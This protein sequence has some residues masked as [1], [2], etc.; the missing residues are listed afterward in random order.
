LVANDKEWYARIKEGDE[1]AFEALFRAHYAVLCGFARKFVADSETA[2]E[3]VQELFTQMWDRRAT[4]NPETSLKAYLFTAIRNSCLNHLKH[5]AV[6]SRHQE[7]ARSMEVAHAADPSEALQTAELEARIHLEIDALPERCREIF[8]LSRFQGL[9]YDEIAQEL[10][11]SPRTVE[12]QIGKALKTLRENLTE[13]LPMIIFLLGAN[14]FLAQEMPF[15]AG[16]FLGPNF[17]T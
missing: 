4:L 3:L 9:K 10:G 1:S 17:F 7:H 14:H 12:V 11:I 15:A 16:I 13:W 2:E 8:R 6:K 5:L